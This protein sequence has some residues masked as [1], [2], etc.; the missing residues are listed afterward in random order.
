MMMSR[1]TATGA[2]GGSLAAGRKGVKGAAGGAGAEEKKV[3]K[4]AEYLKA[5]DFTG[6]LATL[7]F[8]R[9]TGDVEDPQAALLWAGYCAFHLCQFQRAFDS[10]SE[11]LVNV[12]SDV[13]CCALCRC[14]LSR[15][16]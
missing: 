12:C 8:K 14:L 5:R 2:K 6:A 9:K 1:A 15:W 7:E 11:L 16:L 3:D 13:A 4:V 10:Y